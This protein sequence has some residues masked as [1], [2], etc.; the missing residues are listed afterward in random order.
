MAE[1]H[2]L[3]PYDVPEVLAK[4]YYFIELLQVSIFHHFVCFFLV[5]KPELAY[6]LHNS[7]EFVLKKNN[8]LQIYGYSYNLSLTLFLILLL[9]YLRLEL[10][11]SDRIYYFKVLL[12]HT[13]LAFSWSELSLR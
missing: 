11:R 9:L 6:I 7:K 8:W 5:G 1:Q 4:F 10:F 2:R 12:A 3:N 13:N